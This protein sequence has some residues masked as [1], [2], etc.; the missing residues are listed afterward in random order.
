MNNEQVILVNGMQRGGTN[1]VWNLLQSHPR[2]VSPVL[3]TG[4]IIYPAW[5]ARGGPGRRMKSVARRLIRNGFPPYLRHI[6]RKLYYW[7]MATLQDPHNKYRN[8]GEIYT[9][10]ELQRTIL[11]TKL[12]GKDIEVTPS[13]VNFF[14]ESW[15]VSVIRNGLAVCEGWVRRGIPVEDAAVAYNEAINEIL[16]QDRTLDRHM[17]VK[18][19]D[20]LKDPFGELERLC[21]FTGIDPAA[22]DKIRIKNKK[23][24]TSNGSHGLKP[25]TTEGGKVWVGRESI[26][27]YLDPAVTDRQIGRL[28]DADRD[29]VIRLAGET[30]VRAGY[31]V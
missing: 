14:R 13:L 12:V 24:I 18:F 3:E 26:R 28:S 19:E 2:V 6:D 27:D 25:G 29:A 7:K 11:A 17:L 23:T 20:C 16:A 22:V 30:M 10:E 1:V 5:M 15:V 9:K 8:E 21:M 4:Q 31:S